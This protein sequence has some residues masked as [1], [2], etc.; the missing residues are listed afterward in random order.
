MALE[1]SGSGSGDHID[2]G[3]LNLPNTDVL[4]VCAWVY[5]DSFTVGDQRIISKATGQNEED[6]YMMFSSNGN[7][8]MRFRLKTGGTTTTHF[9]DAATINTGQWYH[10]GVVYD[11]SNVIFYRNGQQTGTSAKSGDIDV[12]GGIETRIADNPGANRKE[13]DGKLADVRVYKRALSASKMQTIYTLKGADGIFKK[14][15]RRWTLKGPGG[16]TAS[17]A[18][19]IH[20][21]SGNGHGTPAG[22]PV[23]APG[24]IVS[25][26]RKPV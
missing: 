22:T 17:G 13:F 19:S 10:M 3:T 6:H 1:F 12:G 9:E 14:M 24:P 23:Y 4:T 5:F 7:T 11:G 8:Q 2:V 18:G 26:S 21:C 20:D 16:Q 25:T 15:R